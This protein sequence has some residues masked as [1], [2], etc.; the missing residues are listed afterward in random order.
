[1]VSGLA[2]VGCKRATA[3]S[4]DKLRTAQ[5]SAMQKGDAE[6]AYA[7]LSPQAQARTP[8]AEFVARFAEQKAER[9]AIAT[10]AKT[11]P[12]T[13]A[14][15]SGTTLHEGGRVV[16]W[17]WIGDRYWV[18]SGLPGR[19]TSATPVQAIRAFLDAMRTTDLSAI[20]ATL[21]ASFATAID[22]DFAARAEAI[23]KAL[24]DP[25][26]I[27]VSADGERAEL[28]YEPER[29]LRLEQTPNGWRITGL[30]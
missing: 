12:R 2:L 29:V 24:A 26:A 3:P 11:M 19:P 14:V 1:V 8:K 13:P 22:E 28:R 5:L 23:E 10:A 9:E 21:S 6:A 7:L 25:A 30:E 20:S 18:V 4:P 16:Q 27:V 15:R 17:M